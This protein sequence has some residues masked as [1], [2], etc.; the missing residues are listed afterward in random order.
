MIVHTI[1]LGLG[2]CQQK[3]S[4]Y[5]LLLTFELLLSGPSPLFSEKEETSINLS[6]QNP[7]GKTS[8]AD[9]NILLCVSW[10]HGTSEFHGHTILVLQK[11]IQKKRGAHQQN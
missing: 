4:P 3:P 9:I 5:Y 6:Q 10:S 11:S 1:L 8:Y 2:Y 7:P